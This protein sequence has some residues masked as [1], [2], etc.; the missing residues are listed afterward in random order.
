M[1]TANYGHTSALVAQHVDHQPFGMFAELACWFNAWALA[2]RFNLDVVQGWAIYQHGQTLIAQH[3]AIVRTPTRL[4]DITKNQYLQGIPNPNLLF[5]ADSR[6]DAYVDR[7]ERPYS[8]E[9]DLVSLKL[10]WVYV[11]EHN[12]EIRLQNFGLTVPADDDLA[13]VNE[14]KAWLLNKCN[15]RFLSCP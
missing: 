9:F 14:Y 4:L 12:D 15:E 3:H 11:D 1:A 6:F 10:D 7:C 2:Q 8:A 5:V 13:N